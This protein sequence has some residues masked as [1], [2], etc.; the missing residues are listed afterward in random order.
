MVE[1]RPCDRGVRREPWQHLLRVEE[2]AD[3]AHALGG[4]D[5]RPSR[6]CRPHNACPP[7]CGGGL[8]VRG[9]QR[10]F[11]D[12]LEVSL[13]LGSYSEITNVP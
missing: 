2:R 5:G 3:D 8:H 10:L 9:A 12:A 4:H 1:S 6:G 13:V 11:D 7:P